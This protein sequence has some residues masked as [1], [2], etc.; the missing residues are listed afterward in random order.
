MTTTMRSSSIAVEAIWDSGCRHRTE[1][2]NGAKNVVF[3]ALL[4]ASLPSATVDSKPAQV[5]SV[6]GAFTGSPAVHSS[7]S[8]SASTNNTSTTTIITNTN[9]VSRL[10]LHGLGQTRID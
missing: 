5:A 2:Q 6:M 10:L 8:A 4:P 1:F 9:G 7:A 3:V